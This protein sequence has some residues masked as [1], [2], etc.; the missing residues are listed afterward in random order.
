MNA[1]ANCEDGKKIRKRLLMAAKR[2][3]KVTALD[4]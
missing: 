4:A 1:K 3:I 2:V